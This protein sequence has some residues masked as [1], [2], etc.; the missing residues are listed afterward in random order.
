M[1]KINE[2]IK[3]HLPHFGIQAKLTLI[4]MLLIIIIGGISLGFVSFF[5][6]DYVINAVQ[7]DLLDNTDKLTRY[8]LNFAGYDYTLDT[9]FD[10][11]ADKNYSFVI[12]DEKGDYVDSR[13]A[14]AL[15]RVFSDIEKQAPG[16]LSQ[17]VIKDGTKLVKIENRAFIMCTQR[18]T[19]NGYTV[20]FLVLLTPLSN[21]T[22]ASTP[23]S[24]YFFAILVA[25][26]LAI[27]IATFM[28]K[29]ITSN[30]KRLKVRANLLANRRFDVDVPITATDEVG[31]LAAS[32]DEMAKSIQEYDSNQKVFLQ[33]AS[34]ELRTPLM[35]VRGYVEGIKDGVFEDTDENLDLILAQVSRLEKLINDVM[36]LSKI[37]TA[38]GMLK[39]SNVNIQEIVDESFD[40]VMG[41]SIANNINL[42]KIN[43][44][45]ID[46]NADSENLKTAITNILSNCLRYAKTEIEVILN[47]YPH[48]ISITISDDGPGIN[49]EELPHIFERFYKGKKGKYGL[50]LA[51]A[52]AVVEGH[53]GQ[54]YAYNKNHISD[55]IDSIQTG[56]VFVITLP[57]E[58]KNIKKN[59]ELSK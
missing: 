28:A 54:I 49:P 17:F 51:I 11:V 38:D 20:G 18:M 33:N 43:F 3:R 40:R 44:Q 45:N 37:E 13:D 9:M 15:K 50:G 26:V 1:N 35:S 48:N 58:E 27:L 6:E 2:K 31:E 30:I 14:G 56:A 10:M 22:F 4:F 8:Y 52:K 25:S 32:I 12:L 34:H 55:D 7:R 57:R 41:I 39:F 47:V 46:I 29:T 24:L 42:K 16:A 23:I 19:I 59:F 5:M 53:K 36:Y 21:Y